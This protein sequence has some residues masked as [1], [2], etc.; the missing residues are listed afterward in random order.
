MCFRI[1][2][3]GNQVDLRFSEVVYPSVS[4]LSQP[5]PNITIPCDSGQ[6]F[7]LV[8]TNLKNTEN[9]VMPD[10]FRGKCKPKAVVSITRASQ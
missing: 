6:I 3:F 4:Y 7:H 2:K 5:H 8:K 10:G 9:K 1:I